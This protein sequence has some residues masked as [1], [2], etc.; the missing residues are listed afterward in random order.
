M[1]VKKI[2]LVLLNPVFLWCQTIITGEINPYVMTRTSDRS[3]IDL[4]F[5]LLSFQIDH[6]FN[7]F[8]I[9][10]TSG[11]EY[12]YLSKE[13]LFTL[14]EAYISFYPSWGE[15]KAGKQIHSWGSVDVINPTDNLNS[16]DYYYMFKADAGK[17]I[18]SLSLSSIFYSESYQVELVLQPKFSPNRIPYA[19]DDF[20]LAPDLKPNINHKIENETE[21][22]FRFQ[23]SLL[24]SDMSFSFFNGIDRIPSVFKGAFSSDFKE[25]TFD[26]GYRKTS[27][28]GTDLVSFIG[29]FTLRAEGALYRTINKPIEDDKESLKYLLNQE[30][31]YSQFVVQFEYTTE[32]DLMLSAQFI[33]SELINN[34]SNWVA[35]ESN[36]PM[37]LPIPEF[38]P[39][40]GTPFAMFTDRALLVSSS[41]VLMDDQLDIS[42]SIMTNL[43]ETGLMISVGIGYSPILNW[44]I[45]LATTQ[46]KGN[47]SPINP[48]TLMEDFSHIRWG[49]LYN[50]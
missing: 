11:L 49:L 40:M 34:K 14:R 7:A 16:Y 27:V 41:G 42:G 23:T 15:I 32:N 6:S 17:K 35:P 48:F 22:G 13:P 33:G 44:K 5:R 25:S 30:I 46:F 47:E 36:E 4:P 18:G 26:L 43:S 21:Y 12:R 1:P 2:I 9:K 50:F 31:I 28:Y 38:S 39:G 45:E 37:E 8:D 20:P 19:E 3:Q 24:D 10:T 29:D